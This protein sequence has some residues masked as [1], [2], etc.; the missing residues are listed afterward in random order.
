MTVF[1]K[2]SEKLSKSFKKTR[3][4]FL[5]PGILLALI[6]ISW[7]YLLIPDAPL[8]EY[9]FL[10]FLNIVVF[11]LAILFSL[12]SLRATKNKVEFYFGPFFLLQSI[13][14]EHIQSVESINLSWLRS[15]GVSRIKEGVVY[16][17]SGGKA[18]KFNLTNG[19]VV[20]V[21]VDAAE[22]IGSI[23]SNG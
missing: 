15:F 8:N 2:M 19:R 17:L 5:M 1:L 18:T 13:R 10:L 14:I 22:A 21:G 7:N 12:V 4:G 23:V 9:L 6:P 3:F 16:A 11:L 20:I